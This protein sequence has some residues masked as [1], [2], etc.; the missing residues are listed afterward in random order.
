M[1]ERT[2]RQAI[3]APPACRSRAYP[4]TASHVREARSFL[5][6]ILNDSPLTGDA[7][8]CL[9]ELVT[10]AICHSN[11][12]RP[13]GTFTIRASLHACLRRAEVEAQGGPWVHSPHSDGRSGRGLVSVSRLAAPGG[14][15]GDGASAPVVW[16]TLARP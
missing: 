9:S 8:I 10:N 15:S 11:S 13:G 3:T 16:F 2:A 4:A 6:A 5:A 7:L 12:A 1:C 14:I